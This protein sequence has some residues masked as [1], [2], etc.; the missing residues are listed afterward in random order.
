MNDPT[1]PLVPARPPA[2]IP[3]FSPHYG[4][5]LP[6]PTPPPTYEW[7][8]IDAFPQHG[9]KVITLFAPWCN[10]HRLT[11][12]AIPFFECPDVA[13][14]LGLT[15]SDCYRDKD[16][17]PL[18]VLHDGLTCLLAANGKEVVT[19]NNIAAADQF[20]IDLIRKATL[21]L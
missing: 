16:G 4:R 3:P 19:P 6:P 2:A 11:L 1:Q 15:E 12:P 7:I 10:L 14:R 20:R 18:L 8:G 17:T 5:T 9:R 21:A 13:A